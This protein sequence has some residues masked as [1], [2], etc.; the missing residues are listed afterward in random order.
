[1]SPAKKVEVQTSVQLWS[2]RK[3]LK[4]DFEGTLTRIAEMGFDGV[5]F[6]RDFGPYKEDPEGLKKFLDSIGLKV[7]G[8][9]L[10]FNA[11]KPENFDKTVAFYKA[12]GA[13]TLIIPK[14]KRAF[15]DDKV[16]V[17]IDELVAI[18]EKL[19][20]HG[21]KTGYHNHWQEFE[22]FYDTTFWDYIAMKTPKNV[23][24]QLDVGWTNYAEK[25]AV[26]YISRY[27]GRTI[28]THFK[29][30]FAKSK[31]ESEKA[32]GHVAIIGRDNFD[33]SAVIEACIKVGGTNWFVIEQEEYPLGL[34]PL[35]A[36][37][38]SKEGFDAI[39]AK[40]RL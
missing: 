3:T 11:F 36:V 4:T 25:N 20:V 9:H 24:M 22:E 38:A 7:S 14:D 15:T 33:W 19:K 31:K 1:M 16:D 40:I 17:F 29:P 26:D 10:G 18:S 2:V 21:L 8:A 28:T 23:V 27:Q 32:M 6:A 5:E 34:T 37:K 39:V 30:Q 35:E 12:I 13:P